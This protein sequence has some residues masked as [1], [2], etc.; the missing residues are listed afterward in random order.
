MVYENLQINAT[1][2]GE[3]EK[4]KNIGYRG[5][6]VTTLRHK[7]MLTSVEQIRAVYEDTSK[8]LCV[9]DI[10]KLIIIKDWPTGLTTGSPGILCSNFSGYPWFAFSRKNAKFDQPCANNLF[11]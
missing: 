11:T 8:R 4:L 1:K 6:E 3:R 10:Y 7:N 9:R 2:G 5:S